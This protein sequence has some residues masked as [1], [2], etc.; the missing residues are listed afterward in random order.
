LD[1]ATSS[2]DSETEQLIQDSIEKMMQGRTSIVIAHRLSTIQKAD[3][4]LVLNKGEIVETGTHQSLL[5][6]GGYYTQLH[7]MQLKMTA[8]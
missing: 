8:I 5:E 2:V 6:K 4:I 3:Q 1:E 7:Q